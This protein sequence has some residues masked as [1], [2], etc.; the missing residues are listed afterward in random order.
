MIYI[1]TYKEFEGGLCAQSLGPDRLFTT[2]WTVAHQAPLSMVFSRQDYWGGLPFLPPGD[3]SDAGIEP[4]SPA[5]QAD[6]LPSEPPGKPQQGLLRG[7]GARE[8][9][10]LLAQW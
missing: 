9:A 6:F 1:D 3:L 2:P 10:S 8:Q 5:L 4:G 7:S